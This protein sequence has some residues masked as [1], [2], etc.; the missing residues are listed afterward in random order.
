MPGPIE[1]P[2]LIVGGGPVG[3]A[4]AVG[5]RHFG[6]DCMVVEKHAS[7]LDFPKGRRVTTRTV[8]IFRQWGLEGSVSDVS[9]PRADS[10]FAFEGE[11]LLGDDFRRREL[12]VDDV[13]PASPTRELICSQERLEPVLREWAQQGGADVRLSTELVGFRQDN[14]GVTADIVAKGAPVSVHAPYMVA[15]DGLNGRTRDALGVGR[16]GPGTLGRRVSI[17]FEADIEMRMKDRQSALYWLRQ[18]PGS[19]F[20]AVDN[21]NRWLFSAPLPDTEPS[22]RLTER[23]CI[24]LVH[25]GLGDDGVEVRIIGQRFWEP[26]ALVADRFQAGRVFLA[27]DAAHVTTPEGGLGMNCGIADAHNL[28][29]KLHGVLAGWA[30][31]ALL[32]SYEPERRPHAI[33]CVDASLGPARPPNPI[34][35]LVLGHVLESAAI[36]SDHTGTPLIRDPIGQYVPAGRPGHRAPH[37]WLEEGRSTLDLFGHTFVALTDS[38]GKRAMESAADGAR[39]TGIPLVVHVID[40]ATWH[41]LY[42]VERG[43]GVLVRP[44]GYVAWRSS[45]PPKSDELAAALQV[46]VGNRDNDTNVE[47]NA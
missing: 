13:N 44:D 47:Q 24:E 19:L 18:P 30:G 36:T 14:D 39:A 4:M 12:P 26:T 9:L 33:A 16:S 25:S 15:A 1:V 46:A 37:V 27:G 17:L 7:T 22:D 2:V 21:K 38:P 35:G 28:A 10:L 5:L 20:V 3:L 8:E 6:V 23:R 34:D 29:W 41:E 40:A 43:G 32:E 31:S 45:G 42:G 11:T